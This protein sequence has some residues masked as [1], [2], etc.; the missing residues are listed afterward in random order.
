[1]VPGVKHL[2]E[3]GR[4][5]PELQAKSRHKHLG[6]LGHYVKLDEGTSVRITAEND[7]HNRRRRR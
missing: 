6:T 2:E 3:K 1:M 5:A 4:S 7:D